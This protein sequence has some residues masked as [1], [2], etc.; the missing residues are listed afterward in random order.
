M[1]ALTEQTFERPLF[2]SAHGALT[3]AF[4][5]NHGA[6]K[7]SYLS[8]LADRPAPPGRGLGGLDGAGQAGMIRAE[9]ERLSE[10][11]QRILLLRFSTPRSNCECRAPCCSGFRI[12]PEWGTALDWMAMHV[13]PAAL[14]GTVSNYRLRQSLVRRY[15]SDEKEQ[16]SMVKIADECR[17]KRDTATEHNKRV[18]AYLEEEE[19]RA[20]AEI[21]GRLEAAGVVGA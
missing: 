1:N 6:V 2:R 3:F 7:R 19:R 13:L 12:N 15:F 18:V 17:V 10:V 16:K 4:T 11:R 5:F 9:V 8:T 20:E 14:A 21:Q